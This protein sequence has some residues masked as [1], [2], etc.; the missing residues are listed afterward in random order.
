MNNAGAQN[1][2]TGRHQ[3]HFINSAIQRAGAPYAEIHMQAIARAP[4]AMTYQHVHRHARRMT[5]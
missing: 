1:T 2:T 3:S 4:Q 5:R